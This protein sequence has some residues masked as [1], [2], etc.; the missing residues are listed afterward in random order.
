[1]THE[2][3][4]TGR[5]P[6]IHFPQAHLR[7]SHHWVNDPN[8]L[9]H[10]DGHYH[11]YFQYNPYGTEHAHMH[12]GH[13]RSPDLLHW[14]PLP[15]AL[16]PAPDGDDAD[17]VWSGNAVEAGEGLVAFY[18]ARRADRWWQPV[19]SAHSH[20]GGRTFRKQARPLIPVAPSGTTMFRDPYVWRDGDRWRMLVGSALRD[21]RAAAQ[22]YVSEDLERWEYT[23]AFLARPPEPLTG[24]GTTEGGWECVQYAPLDGRRGALLLSAWNPEE[25]AARTAVYTGQDEGTSFLAG[26]PQPLDHGPDFYAPAVM[27]VPEGPSRTRWLLWAWIW[28]ARD[29]ERVGAYSAWAEEVGWAGMLTVPREIGLGPDGQLT[30]RPARETE[31]LRE[32]KILDVR[33]TVTSGEPRDLARTGRAFDLTARLHRTAAGAAAGIRLITTEDGSEYL[34][35]ALD[36][37]T[38]DLVA[39]RSRASLDPRALGGSW[40]V[41]EAAGPGGSV[42]VRVLVDHS[43][44]E[45]FLDDGRTL[46][47]RFYPTGPAP[48]RLQARSAAGAARVELSAWRLGCLRERRSPKAPLIRRTPV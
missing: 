29:A 9:V 10:H 4:T 14:E 26:A 32:E 19:M 13:Y 24:G 36:P 6:D 33:T 38:G 45:I 11:V 40:R 20:D 41:P 22:H 17:G 44:A 7:P 43:V 25:G 18:S 39:D 8:G 3:T 34:D 1:M 15:V 46:T 12:W 37:D 21:G 35:I 31:L 42:G 30:Q 23:G 2:N 16:G 28:E 47:L 48:W 5:S 27:A